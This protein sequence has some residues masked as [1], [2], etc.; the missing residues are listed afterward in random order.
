M[1]GL[2]EKG[3]TVPIMVEGTEAQAGRVTNVRSHSTPMLEE[4]PGPPL[5]AVLQS[6]DKG[7]PPWT[8]L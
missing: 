8:R 5:R 3:I 7:L 4:E 6:A 1:S 2:G